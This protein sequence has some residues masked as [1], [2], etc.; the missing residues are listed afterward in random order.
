M[1]KRKC[2]NCNGTGYVNML[3]YPT[4][5][6]LCCYC[7]SPNIL[8]LSDDNLWMCLNDNC[9]HYEISVQHCSRYSTIGGHNGEV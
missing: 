4:F 1:T 2:H 6:P 9:N 8:Y 3:D 5:R 7:G